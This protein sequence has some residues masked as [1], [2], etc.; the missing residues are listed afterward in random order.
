MSYVIKNRHGK[1]WQ[2]SRG[3]VSTDLRDATKYEREQDAHHV[4]AFCVFGHE[5]ATVVAA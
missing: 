3:F 5:R 4:S 2:T 1:Y